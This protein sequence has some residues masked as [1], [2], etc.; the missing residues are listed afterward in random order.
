[1]EGYDYDAV[2]AWQVVTTRDES[3]L[4]FLALLLW[5]A[6]TVKTCFCTRRRTSKSSSTSTNES[7]GARTSTSDTFGLLYPEPNYKGK[8]VQL[9]AAHTV[10]LRK[11]ART[12]QRQRT[13]QLTGPR[14]AAQPELLGDTQVTFQR[15]G[16]LHL[17]AGRAY[18]QSVSS[19]TSVSTS[20][21]PS[22]GADVDDLTM[23]R[24]KDGAS[25]T[26]IQDLA[27]VS[28]TTEQDLTRTTHADE[29]T[30]LLLLVPPP[31]LLALAALSEETSPHEG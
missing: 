10:L 4:A 31:D 11:V 3:R 7:A 8:P 12:G 26:W 21:S 30:L 18:V 5:L 14:G 23:W 19:S 28:E 16:S 25:E 1:M 20:V 17:F 6:W 24:P 27:G 15:K 9:R 13:G 2:R 22:V 29:L